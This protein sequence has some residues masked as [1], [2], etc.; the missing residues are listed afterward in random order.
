MGTMRLVYLS[1][2]LDDA[3]LSAGGYLFEEA[4]RGRNVEIWT[5]MCGV[6][7]TAELS[8][9][10]REMHQKWGTNS[11][12]HTVEVRRAEDRRATTMLGV[13][14]VH[15]DFPD[16]IYRQGTNGH[17]LYADPVQASVRP[18]DAPLASGIAADI[19][20]RLAADDE[21]IC[22][23]AIGHHVDHML[24][25]SAAEKLGRA[26]SY[27]VDVPYVLYHPEELQ[28]ATSGLRRSVQ[29]I[30]E[31]GM[32]M[33]LDAV[34]IYASQISTLYESWDLLREAM[35][36]Y[37]TPAKGIALW[38]SAAQPPGVGLDSAM[39]S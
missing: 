21:I 4:R 27:T 2:H 33:W 14:P 8:D 28:P 36:A 17:W 24:V 6:P 5:L 12:R 38:S 16:A 19:G 23:L 29:Q 20:S 7:D 3:V 30:S 11:A 31:D 18:E 26:L 34:Q 10:A 25:R 22:Q 37:W 1:P 9:F 13:K 35:R 32:R 15:F 39:N